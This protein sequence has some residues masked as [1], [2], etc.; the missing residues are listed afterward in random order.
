MREREG[1]A[2][3]LIR[4]RGLKPHELPLD[5]R[6]ELADRAIPLLKPGFQTNPGSGS[7]ALDPV[8]VPASS[9]SA[10]VRTARRQPWL[11][12]AISDAKCPVERANR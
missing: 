12:S 8:H 5:A 9:R 3:S 7:R 2:A 4:Q 1:P 6:R 10:P 11:T